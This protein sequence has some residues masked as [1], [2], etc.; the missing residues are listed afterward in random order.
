MACRAAGELCPPLGTE[1]KQGDL[2]EQSS[3]TENSN[4]GG[5]EHQVGKGCHDDETPAV[6]EAVALMGGDLDPVLLIHENDDRL[7]V[8]DFLV[9]HGAVGEDDDQIAGDPQTG[10]RAIQ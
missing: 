9:G 10:G 7:V 6:S 4:H 2:G 8:R 1:K 3:A 5:L